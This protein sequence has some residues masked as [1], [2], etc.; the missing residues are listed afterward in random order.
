MSLNVCLDHQFCT[1]LLNFYVAKCNLTSIMYIYIFHPQVDVNLV[2]SASV[3][4]KHSSFFLHE[5]HITKRTIHHPII[6]D[7]IDVWCIQLQLPTNSA[8]FQISTRQYSAIFIQEFHKNIGQ[9]PALQHLPISQ[10]HILSSIQ[11][12]TCKQSH[13]QM[14]V[15]KQITESLTYKQITNQIFIL[16]KTTNHKIFST[17]F[18]KHG[19]HKHTKVKATHKAN[20]HKIK[21]GVVENVFS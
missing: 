8:V 19:L 7:T 3:N 9:N 12:S 4:T 13:N 15:N 6:N 14:S 1:F 2:T 21:I 18:F 5:I 16:T 20:S 11:Q 10:K 17:C